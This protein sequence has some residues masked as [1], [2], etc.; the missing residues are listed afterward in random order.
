MMLDL[1]VQPPAQIRPGEMLYPP[2]AASL[3]NET[4]I[5]NELSHTWAVAS[6]VHESGEVM[7]EYL[8]GRLADSA[9]PLPGSGQRHHHSHGHS[10]SSVSKDRAYFYFSDLSIRKTGRYR[11]RLSLMQMDYSRG[12]SPEG[13]AR[14]CECVESRAIV[15]EDRADNHTKPSKIS[16]LLDG[17]WLTKTRLTRKSISSRLEERRTRCSFATMIKGSLS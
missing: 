14:V 9:H 17:I 12:S 8:D 1:A 16:E 7:Q 6:L 15:V 11:I 10:S 3:S 2:I 13:E 5:Y 4:S